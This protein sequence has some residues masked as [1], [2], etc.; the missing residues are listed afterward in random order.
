MTAFADIHSENQIC[1]QH[2][3]LS[4]RFGPPKKTQYEGR[5]TNL[6]GQIILWMADS[7]NRFSGSALIH[8]AAD[9]MRQFTMVSS[10]PTWF[11]GGETGRTTREEAHEPLRTEQEGPKCDDSTEAPDN[12]S[13]R[14]DL[15]RKNYCVLL[16]GFWD[17]K[18]FGKE[19][20]FQRIP[21]RK[22]DLCRNYCFSI[23]HC[24]WNLAKITLSAVF[25]GF[26]CKFRPLKNMFRTLENGHSIHHQS[27]PPPSAGWAMFVGW[28]CTSVFMGAWRGSI[29]SRFCPVALWGQTV[30][31]HFKTAC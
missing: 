19:G 8:C 16:E 24:S 29:R 1:R 17:P 23:L 25:P 20:H 3:C 22:Q 21:C 7:W 26:C 12:T 6:Y 15:A 31:E 9:S 5:T 13:L 11:S 27:I 10:W 2:H 28:G 18:I 14:I 4:I 30:L